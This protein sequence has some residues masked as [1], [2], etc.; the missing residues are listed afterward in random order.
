VPRGVQPW[1]GV[2]FV[3]RSDEGFVLKGLQD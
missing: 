1:G 3:D 2:D